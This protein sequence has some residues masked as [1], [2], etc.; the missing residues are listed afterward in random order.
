MKEEVRT[1]R[2]GGVLEVTLDRPK[3]NAIDHATSRAQRCLH[4]LSR[5]SGAPRRR[6]HRVAATGSFLPAKT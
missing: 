5:R 2:R 6:H 3:A 4:G 1:E